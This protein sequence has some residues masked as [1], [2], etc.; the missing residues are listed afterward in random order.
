MKF[1]LSKEV[2]I[3]LLTIV[4]GT[5][6]Y[7]GFSFLKG[8]DAFSRTS[9]YHIY[10][11]NVDGLTPGNPV[12]INGLSVGQV[13]DM[14]LDPEKENKVNVTIQLEG[15][16]PLT[17]STR[18]KLVDGSL[19]GGKAIVLELKPGSN[20]LEDGAVI[21][22]YKEPSL[23]EALVAKAQPVMEGLD[24]TIHNVNTILDAENQKKISHI[25]SNLEETTVELKEVVRIN[26]INLAVTTQNLGKL[27]TSLVETEKQL[28]PI[29]KDLDAFSDSLKDARIKATVEQANQAIAQLNEVVTKVNKG[30]GSLGKLI[31]SDSLHTH[32]DKTVKDLDQVF[33]DIKARPKRYVHFSVFG[34]KDK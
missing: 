18:A 32:L 33:I 31:N 9:F 27:S 5:M 30:Q 16:M 28:K 6:L 25:L 14:V 22:S 23:T 21:P 1:T 24:K 19:L 4:S 7:T 2:K 17:D 20:V 11:T 3:A 13:K 10:Y 8:R 26:K 15:K 12:Y 34:K 29:L